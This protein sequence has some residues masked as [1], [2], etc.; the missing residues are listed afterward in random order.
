MEGQRFV[1]KND[2]VEKADRQDNL[3]RRRGKGG[4]GF[5]LGNIIR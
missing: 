2:R 5:R 3:P 4:V 1:S